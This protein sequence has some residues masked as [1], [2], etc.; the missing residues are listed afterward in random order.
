MSKTNLGALNN[1]LFEALERLNDDELMK[2]QGELEMGRA[3]A[4]TMIGRTIVSNASI[5]FN[6]QKHIDE[7]GYTNENMPKALQIGTNDD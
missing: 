7:M 3:K 5:A 2:E 1:H 6:A 4:I